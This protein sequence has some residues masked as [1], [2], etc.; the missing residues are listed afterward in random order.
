MCAT[1]YDE[2]FI[3]RI[4][5]SK[6]TIPPIIYRGK[7]A[8]WVRVRV[9]VGVGVGVEF[10]LLLVDID[11][12]VPLEGS[13][14]IISATHLELFSILFEYIIDALPSHLATKSPTAIC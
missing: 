11:D 5:V 9:G 6:I 12:G 10:E 8:S 3:R 4:S 7:S 13:V 2:L 1:Y 14:L